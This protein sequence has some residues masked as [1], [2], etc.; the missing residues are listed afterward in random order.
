M[1]ATRAR[2]LCPQAVFIPPRHDLYAAVS[3]EVMAIFRSYT[4]QVEPL[5]LDE[6]FLDVPGALRRAGPPAANARL[7]RGPRADPQGL[8]PSVRVPASPSRAK[9]GPERRPAPA[10]PPLPAPPLPS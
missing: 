4:P 5:A 7:V 8:T 10:V 6:A 2:R 9:S 3:R 1:P